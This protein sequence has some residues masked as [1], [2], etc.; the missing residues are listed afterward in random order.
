V[1][2]Q[3]AAWLASSVLPPL[4]AL[5]T[6]PATA[7]GHVRG[8]LAMWR[9]TELSDTVELVVSELAA[10]AVNASVSPDGRPAHLD[11]RI[12]VIRVRLLV[13]TTVLVAE[14][15]DQVGGVP[16]RKIAGDADESGRGLHLVHEL[17]NAR[18]GWYHSPSGPGKCVWAE[19]PI[20]G[21]SRPTANP[22]GKDSTDERHAKRH[23]SR[24]PVADFRP[25]ATRA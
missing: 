10:N 2:G 16:A 25:P 24:P 14:V 18:W 12:P 20:P 15:W 7:R 13:D 21:P 5:R 9:L 3:P 22:R 1:S 19:F 4:G 11:G 6:A 8:T 23:G 17:T